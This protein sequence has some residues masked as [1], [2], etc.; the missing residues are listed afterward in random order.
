MFFFSQNGMTSK[1]PYIN[2]KNPLKSYWGFSLFFL[3]K[4][5]SIRYLSDHLYVFWILSEF[6][7]FRLENSGPNQLDEFKWIIRLFLKPKP[8]LEAE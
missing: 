5:I 2:Y 1:K 7:Q 4:V 3:K 6:V 8:S